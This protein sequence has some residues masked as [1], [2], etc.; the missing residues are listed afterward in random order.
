MERIDRLFTIR[1]VQSTEADLKGRAQ[2]LRDNEG[3]VLR[4]PRD[5]AEA[6]AEKRYGTHWREFVDVSR[7]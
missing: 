3:Q 1:K 2:P 6:V 5:V 7:D 4:L